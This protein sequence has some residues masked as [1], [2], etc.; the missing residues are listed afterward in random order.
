VGISGVYW[1]AGD[2]IVA[3]LTVSPEV[4]AHAA[5]YMMWAVVSP[6]ISVWSF[7]LDGIFIG[8]TRAADMRNGMIISL[9]AYLAAAFVLVPLMGNHGLWLSLMVLMVA[10]A[11]TLGLLYPRV[12]R[13]AAV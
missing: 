7:Q 3:L 10:R 9:V 6:L 11:V 1:L 4:R 12:E 5:E 8:A 13:M 2:A